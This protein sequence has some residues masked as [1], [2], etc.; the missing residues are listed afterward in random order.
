MKRLVLFLALLTLLIVSVAAETVSRGG[1]N[2][3]AVISSSASETVLQYQIGTFEKTPV[4]IT[5]MNGFISNCPR[6]A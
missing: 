2:S 1:G 4:N 6:K 5:E 3:V